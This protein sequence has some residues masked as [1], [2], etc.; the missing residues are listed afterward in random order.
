[1]PEKQKEIIERYAAIVDSDYAP[2]SASD[3]SSG[4][5]SSSATEDDSKGSTGKDGFFKKTFGKFKDKL[6][7]EDEEDHKPDNKKKD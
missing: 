7:S 6:S 1:L 2:K 3:V 4:D 5:H